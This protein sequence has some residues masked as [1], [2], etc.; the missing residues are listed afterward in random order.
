M[1][2]KDT[3]TIDIP[4]KTEVPL[5]I[6]VI[7]KKLVKE[8]TD[9]HLDLRTV[10]MGFKLPNM[11]QNYQILGEAADSVENVVDKNVVK[12][13]KDLNGLLLSFHYTDLKTFSDCNGQLRMVLNLSHKQD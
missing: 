12:K 7:A 4:V 5:V 11:H 2:D 6:A 1:P 3:V 10:T 9:K 13:I 8:Q